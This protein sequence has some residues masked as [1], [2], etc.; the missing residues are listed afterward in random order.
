MIEIVTRTAL[1]L[2]TGPYDGGHGTSSSLFVLLHGLCQEP[3]QTTIST[4]MKKLFTLLAFAGL[5]TAATAQTTTDAPKKEEAQKVEKTHSCAGH[6]H[7]KA[8]GKAC[9]AGKD[10]AKADASATD[11]KAAGC[12]A[13]KSKDAKACA[14]NHGEKKADAG[15]GH[16]HAEMTEHVCADACKQGVHAYACGEKGHTCSADCHAKH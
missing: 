7:A 10:G 9:C 2:S 16:E 15:D 12:C 6:D 14:C 13:G 4:T 8:D 5:M 11:A 1:G 3:S